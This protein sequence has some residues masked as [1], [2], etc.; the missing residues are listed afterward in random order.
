M[1]FGL[2]SSPEHLDIAKLKALI[3]EDFEK[4]Q[5]KEKEKREKEKQER[6][7]LN[8]GKDEKP[9]IK[10]EEEKEVDFE[11]LFI[12]KQGLQATKGK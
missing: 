12:V 8:K 2:I 6:A 4:D 5:Q 7:L 10:E 9:L 11:K 1:L 3:K